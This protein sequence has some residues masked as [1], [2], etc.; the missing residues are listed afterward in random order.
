MRN[1]TI[2][3]GRLAGGAG[4]GIANQG[5]LTLEQVTVNRNVA[6]SGGGITNFETGQLTLNL[7]D[8]FLLLLRRSR[9]RLLFPRCLD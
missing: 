9:R 7:A 3:N 4:G 6:G 8:C 2:T 1:L 5:T